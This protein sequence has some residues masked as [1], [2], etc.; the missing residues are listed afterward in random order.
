LEEVKV[1]NSVNKKEWRY[2]C[3]RWFDTSEDDRQIE[4]DLFTNGPTG[5]PPA[6]YRVTVVTGNVR[7]AGT[8]ANVY[9][10]VVGDKGKVDK[11]HLDN[12][13][14]NFERG[15]VDVFAISSLDLGEIKHI[16]IEH[17]GKGLGAG[18]FLNKVRKKM[19]KIK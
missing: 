9:L 2:P 6:N 18:W 13:K 11:V 17:D 3:N 12:S 1:T 8:D 5:R 19:K 7:G 16:V 14:N 15:R 4:R 10:T